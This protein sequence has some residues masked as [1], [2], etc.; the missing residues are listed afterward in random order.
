MRRLGKRTQSLL[1]RLTRRV[2][3]LL[4]LRVLSVAV[5]VELVSARTEKGGR[6][7]LSSSG[8]ESSCEVSCGGGGK[9]ELPCRGFWRECGLRQGEDS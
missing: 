7:Q 5:R 6:E 9:T 2:Q 8:Q 3:D 1:Q 4:R